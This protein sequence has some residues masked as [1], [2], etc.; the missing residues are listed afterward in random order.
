MLQSV[1]IRT[2]QGALLTLPLQDVVSGYIL[3]EIEGLDPVKATIVSSS[4]AN[5]DGQQYH[6]ARREMRN[7]IM[8]IGLEPD[9]IHDSVQDLRR[10]LYDFLMPKSIANLRFVMSDGLEVDIQGRVESLETALFTKEPTVDISLLCLDPDLYDA[11]AVVLAGNT[12][13]LTTETTIA[14]D[15]TVDTGVLLQLNVNRTLSAFTVYHRDPSG[16]LRSLDYAA[17]TVNGDIVKISTV[18]GN[19]FARK[20]T[21]GVETSALYAVSPQSYWLKLQPGTNTFRVYA[22]GA[23]VPYTLT[24]YNRYGGL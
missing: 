22:T 18:T 6:S 24:Y 9:Y 16:T 15:G 13:S 2:P 5:L 1:E 10:G 12:T 3:E 11:T 21:S 23:A 7:I 4:F 19:K 14:Y 17:G 20:T 8:K